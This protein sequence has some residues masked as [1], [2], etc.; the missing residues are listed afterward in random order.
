MDDFAIGG[1]PNNW[2]STDMWYECQDPSGNVYFYNETT[3]ESQWHAPEWIEETDE[4]SGANYYVKLNQYD[5]TPL[6]ST[7]S[8]PQKFSRLVRSRGSK[9][10]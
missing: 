2:P 3:G 5:A 4:A 10:R 6:N 8:K 1:K 7:W 9:R